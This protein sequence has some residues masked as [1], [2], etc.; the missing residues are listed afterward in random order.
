MSTKPNLWH[1][2]LVELAMASSV[3]DGAQDIN[4]LQRVWR[5]A[6]ALH[7]A[8]PEAEALVVMSACY[9]HDLVSL[10]KNHPERSVASRH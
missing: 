4:H 5:N 1:P 10:P 7:P 3:S 2:Q 8:C 9:L 6:Q